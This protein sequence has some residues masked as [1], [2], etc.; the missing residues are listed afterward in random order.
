MV[1]IIFISS[2]F[3]TL[4]FVLRVNN[5]FSDISK[6]NTASVK[7]LDGTFWGAS[8]FNGDLSNWVSTNTV[9]N[10]DQI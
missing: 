7:R 2:F 3:C 9:R 5:D 8:K 4:V 10:F 6:W 1:F